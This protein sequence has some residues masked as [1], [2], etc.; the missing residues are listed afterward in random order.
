MIRIQTVIEEVVF[1]FF[2]SFIGKIPKMYLILFFF[3]NL[4]GK[5]CLL[6]KN[7]PRGRV[8]LSKIDCS[9]VLVCFHNRAFYEDIPSITTHRPDV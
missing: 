9:K 7:P 1:S 4:K 6:Y 8:I 2:L 3:Q 5:I